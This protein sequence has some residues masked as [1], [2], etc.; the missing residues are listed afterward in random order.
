MSG[1]T[2]SKT[3]TGGLFASTPSAAPAPAPAAQ[4]PAPAHHNAL[5][6]LLG[7]GTPASAPAPAQPAASTTSANLMDELFGSAP[8]PAPAP[9][10]TSS[11]PFDSLLGGLGSTQTQ[12]AQAAAA[13]ATYTHAPTLPLDTVAP[14]AFVASEVRPFVS[15]VGAT[16]QLLAHAHAVALYGVALARPD[17]HAVALVVRSAAP[18]GTPARVAVRVAPQPDFALAVR[19]A[20]PATPDGATGLALAAVPAGTKATCLGVVTL[21]R[22]DATLPRAPVVFAGTLAVDGASGAPAAF[23]LPPVDARAYLRPAPATYTTQRIGGV[24]ARHACERRVTL[25]AAS[26]A[27]ATQLLARAVHAHTASTIGSEAILCSTLALPAPHEALVLYHCRAD[28]KGA[29]VVAVRSQSAATT[30]AV[31]TILQQHGQPQGQL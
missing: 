11:S 23:A 18:A 2:A 15:G 4:A 31:A 5:D 10:S 28:G 27:Q 12:P 17:C 30:D 14:S 9:A 1:S 21:A 26:I 20:P 22:P 8:A 6:D 3:S 29:A 25:R 7:L 16:L 13:P 19:A 24:W